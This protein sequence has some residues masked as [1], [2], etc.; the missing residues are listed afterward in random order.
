LAEL[1]PTLAGLRCH[2]CGREFDCVD[3]IYDL[4]P[5]QSRDASSS[6]A[7]QLRRYSAGFSARRDRAWYQPLRALIGRLSNGQLYAWAAREVKR[8]AAGR[9]L[10]L[11]DAGCGDAALPS[12]LPAR[13]AYVGIDFSPRVLARALRYHPAAY[14][15][16]DLNRLPFPD[17]SFDVA[18]SLQALQY[19]ERPEVALAEMARVLKPQGRLLLS[20]PNHQSVKYRWQGV[21]PNQIWRFDAERVAALVSREFEILQFESR[22]IWLPFPV[23]PIHVGLRTSTNVGVAL[24]IA[25]KPKK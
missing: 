22:G 7:R 14:F 24:T 25:A 13:H 5:E 1:E 3:G 8:F 10:T 2:R 11:L 18:I 20:L 23:I 19:L 9:E 6:E 17:A 12:Y 21:P 4:L 16:A 15:R